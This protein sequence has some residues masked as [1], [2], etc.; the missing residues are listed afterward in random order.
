[1]QC[2][3]I[4]TISYLL[5]LFVHQPSHKHYDNSKETFILKIAG[6]K[7]PIALVLAEAPILATSSV[8][9]LVVDN[10]ERVIMARVQYE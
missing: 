4:S 7:A 2:F 8:N 6:S 10:Q 5:L 9:L 3:S 1:M